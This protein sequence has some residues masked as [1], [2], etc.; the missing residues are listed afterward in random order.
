LL[1]LGFLP[2]SVFFN[3]CLI[4]FGVLIIKIGT[5][6]F[7]REL[8]VKGVGNG[9]VLLF[10]D[11]LDFLANLVLVLI[12]IKHRPLMFG[13]LFVKFQLRLDL[14]KRLLTAIVP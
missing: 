9:G 1:E 3:N 14:I 5:T 2:I 6:L 8:I 4:Q 7:L 12:K 13:F 11:F 10:A